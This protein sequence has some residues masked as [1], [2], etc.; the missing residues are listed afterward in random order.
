MVAE[1]LAP[2]TTARARPG[3]VGPCGAPPTIAIDGVTKR[4]GALLALDRVS[5]DVPG[6]ATVA[7]IGA[8]GAGKSTLLA[9]IAGLHRP[10][11]GT[12]HVGGRLV[13]AGADTVTQLG[14]LTHAT[15]LYDQLTGR[16]NLELHARLRGVPPERVTAVL[17]QLDLTAM[18]DRPAGRSS[19]GTRRRLALARTLLHDP[20]VL[21]LDEPFGGLD[22]ISARRLADELEQLR[23]SRTI[24]FSS[25]DLDRSLRLADLV[26]ELAD[27]R[28]TACEPTTTWSARRSPVVAA[29]PAGA[30]RLTEEGAH[31]PAATTMPTTPT[32]APSRPAGLLRT[33]WEVLRKDLTVELRTRAISTSVLVL[34][35]LLATVLGM[36]FEPLAGSPRAVSGILW[37]LVTFT[38]LHGLTRSFD[39]DFR[40]E[41]LAGVLSTGADAAGVYLGRVA[42]T[43][44]LL[45][46]VALSAA[47]AVAVLFA[48]PGLLHVLPQLVTVVAL[49]V[50]GLAAV[51]G[52]LTVLSRHSSL[53][54]TLLPLLFLPLA[55]P[56]LLAG[57]ESVAL[58][59]E[60]GVLDSGWL[61]VLVAYAVGMLTASAVVFER[62]VEG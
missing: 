1:L 13:G 50:V 11:S 10:S 2:R 41:A 59:L 52:I 28:I 39:E 56:V 62:A 58:L 34:A 33:A 15:M 9:V 20:E 21:L 42:S 12:V 29:Q 14:V 16:E 27:G 32:R 18:A 23:G 54:E 38:A 35:A 26:L 6:G 36:A 25:H 4:F 40:D 24:L 5:L 22:P 3:P 55:V 47:V 49:A 44:L 43:T 7:L 19:H 46:V 61:R 51:G 57:V 17:E 53:G 8:N 48:T 37:V 60:T 31:R 30:T 45:L